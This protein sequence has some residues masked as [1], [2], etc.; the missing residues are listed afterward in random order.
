MKNTALEEPHHSEGGEMWAA[1]LM[2]L[3]QI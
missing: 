1:S 3:W 2:M